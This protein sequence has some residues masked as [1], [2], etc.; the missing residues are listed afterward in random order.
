MG[1][2]E[3]LASDDGLPHPTEGVRGTTF[4]DTKYFLRTRQ[5]DVGWMRQVPHIASGIV[6]EDGSKNAAI[7]GMGNGVLT[8]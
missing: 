1:S 3:V 5:Y 7:K 6:R 4:Y 2:C 8:K